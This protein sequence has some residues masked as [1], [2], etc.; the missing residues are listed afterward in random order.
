VSETGNRH[1]RKPVLNLK[2]EVTNSKGEKWVGETSR[3]FS[4]LDY[5]KLVVGNKFELKYNP[6]DKSQV[7]L[8]GYDE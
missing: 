1:D 7:L 6:K 2:F 8:F 3:T 4:V 5:N